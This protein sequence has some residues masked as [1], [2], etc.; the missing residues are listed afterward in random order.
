MGERGRSVARFLRFRPAT[1]NDS[2]KTSIHEWCRPGTVLWTSPPPARP[3]WHGEHSSV[4][5][6]ARTHGESPNKTKLTSRNCCATGMG[7][8]NALATSSCVM[9]S[10]PVGGGSMN[11]RVCKFQSQKQS[12]RRTRQKGNDASDHGVF[13]VRVKLDEFHAAAHK[14]AVM[15]P[16]ALR[17]DIVNASR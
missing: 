10:R 11:V 7:T 16:T 9:N 1:G 17:P 3:T 4:A 15:I 5:F 2:G 6:G 12:T 13:T 14:L 8:W